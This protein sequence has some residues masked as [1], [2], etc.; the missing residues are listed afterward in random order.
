M[1]EAQTSGN[2]KSSGQPEFRLEIAHVLFMD[3]VGYSKR[4]VDEQRQLIEALNRTVRETRQFRKSEAA[5]KLISIPSGDGMALVF[6][7]S[8]EDPVECA[9]QIAEALREKREVKLRMGVHSGPVN[10][11]RDVNDRVNVAGAGINIAQR[12]MDCGDADHILITKRVAEDLAEDSRWRS[13]LHDLGEIEVK[14]G[15]KVG[16][17][18]VCAGQVGN[19]QLPQKLIQRRNAAAKSAPRSFFQA[20]VRGNKGAT[21]QKGRKLEEYDFYPFTINRD[22]IPEFNLKDFRLGMHYFLTNDDYTAARQLIFLGEQNNV[23][24]KLAPD[25]RSVYER[26]FEKYD[27]HGIADD[28]AEYLENYARIVRLIGKSFPDTGIE[29]LLHNLA[30]P[31]HSLSVLENNVTGRALRAGATN[32]LID[33]KRRQLFDEDK[34]NYELNIGGRRFKC[35]TIPIMRKEFGVV[36]AICIN[37]DANYLT[38]TVIRNQSEIEEWFNN[39]LR[40]DMKLDE[41]ILSKDEFDRAQK[42]KRHFKDESA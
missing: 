38:E 8:P 14:H 24:E 39:F 32:L 3:I 28:T 20:F 10:Q 31:S 40:V 29:I 25:E 18:N 41:N 4:G 11:V 15:V 33:L 1:I 19:S 42:G 6:F 7:E 2:G 34:L 5:G 37:I 36:G 26:L 12:V 9:L 17:V 35:T 23:R 21:R 16:V 30:D 27:G 22:N 13:S